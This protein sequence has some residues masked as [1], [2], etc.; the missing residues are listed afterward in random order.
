MFHVD[1]I[2]DFN[3]INDGLILCS[4]FVGSRKFLIIDFFGE[5]LFD[6]LELFI[7]RFDL[8]FIF[9]FYGV[10]C[11]FGRLSLKGELII[12]TFLYGS[13]FCFVLLDDI[14]DFDLI[15]FLDSFIC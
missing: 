4:E 9:S 7:E 15:L 6:L 3:V 13:K 12:I 14:L 2:V 8:K 11:F 10:E 1:L 5:L